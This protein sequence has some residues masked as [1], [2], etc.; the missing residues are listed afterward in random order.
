MSGI[1]E[2]VVNFNVYSE[3]EKLVGVSGEVTMPS[4]ESMT[5]TIGGAG[6][7]GE[8]ESPT[9]GHFSSMSIDIPF[10][11]VTDR[12]FSLFEPRGQTIYLRASQQSYDVASGMMNH[13]G[14]KITLK[15]MPKNLALGTLGVSKMTETTNTLEI[16]YIKI[17][18][19]DK[20]NVKELLE[21]DK[22]NF[23][24]KINGID[25]MAD[26]RSQI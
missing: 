18:E 1:P 11:T 3:N 13:R 14:L 7:A 17:E 19:I 25:Y 8:Y 5:E 26:I 24:Y 22:I 9:P 6:I 4:F 21:I 10:R 15:T 2:K 12:S 16:L 20:G 23:I